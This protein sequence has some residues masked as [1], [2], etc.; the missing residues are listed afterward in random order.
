LNRLERYLII[1][2][3]SNV[4]RTIILSK[5]DLINDLELKIILNEISTRIKNVSIISICNQI[6]NG[7]QEIEPIIEKGCAILKSI[8]SQ[9]LDSY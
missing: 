3:S 9:T 8:E 7:C 5:I 2:D 1:C 4:K 6:N